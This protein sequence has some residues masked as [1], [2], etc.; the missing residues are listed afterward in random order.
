MKTIVLPRMKPAVI[1]SNRYYTYLEKKT[2]TR[3]IVLL[4]PVLGQ[5]IVYFGDRLY[6]D[7]IFALERVKKEGLTLQY[8]S[9]RL[10]N[11]KEAVLAATLNNPAAF[12]HASEDLRKSRSFTCELMRA[13]KDDLVLKYATQRPQNS[14][15]VLLAAIEQN[16]L[17]LQWAGDRPRSS[18]NVVKAAV[19]QN[20]FA[21]M[22]ASDE[23][24]N[25]KE[26][27]LELIVLEPRIRRFLSKEL[28]EDMDVKR[29][30]NKTSSAKRTN[31]DDEASVLTKVRENPY[32]FQNASSRLKR[33]KEFVLKVIRAHIESVLEARKS[34]ASLPP[35]KAWIF[36]NF[37]SR[38]LKE[39]RQVKLAIHASEKV[40]AA[41]VGES[42]F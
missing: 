29:A 6:E 1:S 35:I 3:S 27:V 32:L 17:A 21:F 7:K 12:T 14:K 23:L 41:L 25:E 30:L 28:K 34:G 19:L 10:Q 11:N 16:G 38:E 22:Y 31:W 20:H 42:T 8:M 39:D 2:F 15:T 24:R 26:F 40:L 9:Q 18:R 36:S 37:V 13:R 33:S 4:I 5:I